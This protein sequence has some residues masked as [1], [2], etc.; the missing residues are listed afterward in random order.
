MVGRM[1]SPDSLSTRVARLIRDW[2]VEVESTVW[3]G[4][5]FLP[6]GNRK[7]Q[8]VVLKVLTQPR[9]EWRA[10]E[11]LSAFGGR[12][13]VRVYEYVEGA[14]LLERLTPGSSLEEL[15]V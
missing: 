10:G 1:H 14:V 4:N 2:R 6:F 15:A 12:G 8:A 9:N 5:A 7:G 3:T 11:I 13:M